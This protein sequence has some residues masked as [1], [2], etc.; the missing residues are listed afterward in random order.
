MSKAMAAILS[1]T[2]LITAA[3]PLT[4]VVALSEEAKDAASVLE[5]APPVPNISKFSTANWDAGWYRMETDLQPGD[6]IYSFD[7]DTTGQEIQT[8]NPENYCLAALPAY[9]CGSDYIV[10]RKTQR[11]DVFFIAE[12]DIVVYAAIDFA[13]GDSFSWESGWT[14]TTDTLTTKDGTTY[15]LYRK[16]YEADTQVVIKKLGNDGDTA[17]NFFL[18]ILPVEGETISKALTHH[19]VLPE[20][21]RNPEHD[22]EKRYQYYTNDVYN[23]S[24]TTG[25][26]DGYSVS[27]AAAGDQVALSEIERESLDQ[28]DLSYNT[29]F[30]SENGKIN[31]SPIDDNLDTYW[32]SN[33]FP[34]SVTVD[35][36][37]VKAVNRLLL[38]LKSNWEDRTQS[39][40]V[41]GSMNGETFTSILPLKEYTFQM[42]QG[43][44][45]EM[46]FSST[47]IRYIQLIITSN[48]GSAGGQIS[49]IEVYGP[50]RSQYQ[51]EAG[52]NLARECPFTVSSDSYKG[53][54]PVDG[55]PTT[56]W[57]SN[58][59]KEGSSESLT[60]DLQRVLTVN[61]VALRL[62]PRWG[63][64][65]QRLELQGSA[66]GT[67]YTT[68]VAASEY[69]FTQWDN[70]VSISFEDTAL[71]YIRLVGT[72]N[73]GDSGI[74]IGELEVFG[75]AQTV[76]YNGNRTLEL[77]KASDGGTPLSLTRTLQTPAAGKVV[78][79]TRIKFDK[80]DAAIQ[81]LT[82]RT[83]EGKDILAICQS[84]AEQVQAITNDGEKDMAVCK[85]NAWHTLKLVLDLDAGTGDIWIDHLRKATG[86]TF[87]TGK[88]ATVS[89]TIPESAAHL[90]IDYL[91]VYD[92]T[93]CYTVEETFDAMETDSCP[94]GWTY[95]NGGSVS[96]AAVPFPEDKS[97]KLSS[98]DAAVEMSRSFSAIRGD[99]TVEVRVKPVSDGWITAPLVTDAAGRT[100]AKVAF[101]HNSIFISNGNN[102]AYLCDQEIPYNYYEADNWFAIKLVMNTDTHRYDAYV[103]GARRYAGASFA[104][105]MEEISQI[106]FIAEPGT[107]LYVNDLKIYD[108]ASLSRGLMPEENVFDVKDYGAI[109]DGIT[110]DTAAIAK[111][112]QAAAGTGGTV[113]LQ[114]GVFYTG[115]VTLES[116][117]T[118]F[119]SPSATLYANSDRHAY[120]K[121]IPSNGYNGNKQLGRGILYFQN[122]KNVR[123]TGGGTIFGNG[124]YAYGENDPSDQR[125]CI[126]YFAQSENVVI[127][128]LNLVQSPFWTLVPYESQQITIRRVNITNHAAPNRDGIDPVNAQNVTIEGC[129]I[130]AGDDAICP[131]S[132]N[133]IPMTDIEVRDCLLQ[134]DCNGIKIGTDTQGP[135]SNLSFEDIHIKKVGLS[136]VTIQSIDGSDIENIRFKR[137]DMNDV[138]NALFVCIGNRY[139]MPIPNPG[140]SK[141]LG[142]IR[143]LRF[144][145][146]RFTNPMDHPYS[147]K[148][149]DNIHEMMLI[150]LNPAYNTIGDGVEHRIKD[151][152]FKNVYLEMPGGATTVPAFT[153]GISNGYPEHDALKTSAGWAYTL[154]WADNVRFVNC[155]S[156]ALKPDV[157][158][159]IAQADTTENEAQRALRLIIDEAEALCG[160]NAYSSAPI[161]LRQSMEEAMANAWSIY[162]NNNATM[163][164]SRQAGTALQA[165]LD[166]LREIV[167]VDKSA[168][169][170]AVYQPVGD[171]EQYTEKS[172][173]VY[174]EMLIVATAVLKD[175]EATQLDVNRALTMLS[176]AIEGLEW[177]DSPAKTLIFS[178]ADGHYTR[179]LYG[180]MFY[181]DWKT[182]DNAPGNMAGT[183]ANGAN[184]NMAL[185]ATVTITSLHEDVN[186]AAAW[187]Q[188]GFRLRSS[189]VDGTEMAAKFYYITPDKVAMDEKG[190]FKVVIPLCDIT[191]EHM[192][193]ED[194]QGLNI[195][196][197]VNAPYRF[198]TTQESPDLTL[199]L[200]D[201]RIAAMEETADP[202]ALN[203]A[204]AQAEQI[205]ETL[206][207][208]ESIENLHDALETA[209][210][211][212]EDKNATQ[213]QINAAA[214]SL[215]EAIALL[216]E[217]EEPKP[218]VIYGDI[219]GDRTIAASDALLA[220]QAATG[221]IVLTDGQKQAADVDGKAG[222]TANDALLI[223]QQSTQK[224]TRFP[225]EN[226][227]F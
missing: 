126:L 95:T 80:A 116:D 199:T 152:L 220:L 157:R 138:D 17:R 211:V 67:D 195:T 96:V 115:Q 38:K 61:R 31:G 119:I 225:V 151:V 109:G 86:L 133:Q 21:E 72:A 69:A 140:Y 164:N 102:W 45:I 92:D 75:P 79:E 186:V 29:F 71:R 87:D 10:T 207:T 53:G 65:V 193:W 201:V 131:K 39:I 129:N 190:S 176:E 74:Q 181:T 215:I 175:V 23:Q 210:T 222:I 55:D 27:G 16:T 183:A 154:R 146:I 50:D 121:V 48:T 177:K 1:S 142:S 153:E 3:A 159:E 130:I 98:S 122:A 185:Q 108:S 58:E 180:T 187:R 88:L 149:G 7:Y 85:S 59:I 76:A 145:D 24:C 144:E 13:Y 44:E 219:N 91:K 182:G 213:A 70:A 81:L 8:E 25:L 9:L 191:P 156:V 124:F 15:A 62:W 63:N 194:V 170:E 43:N 198:P 125:P 6:S 202:A 60:V 184:K 167:P 135:V 227:T 12:R 118:F 37:A 192:N 106:H 173:A 94:P 208:V 155:Q 147:Q 83:V 189:H 205:D 42:D 82:A 54:S 111:A 179:L 110:D 2:I 226:T 93:T 28:G 162:E 137:I 40:E 89:Y 18:M 165:V 34:G 97:L 105:E 204:I 99:V 171:L 51:L 158:Q 134:S 161:S 5:Q 136:G 132:G 123:I 223:L 150:G 200:A 120:K 100:A 214:N 117:M 166:T 197:E 33:G 35:L 143:D 66:D 101:Y 20:G 148:K 139:R 141:K 206:Y 127:E 112:I 114:N 49:E 163:E 160:H 128:D 73:S 41:K 209:K 224:I 196:C 178:K 4:S 107:E 168:L 169:Q 68:L 104:Q 57:R 212:V 36:G 217:K 32:E 26:P 11:R 22:K 64:R 52:V 103:D 30:S 14:K 113:L 46:S 90:Q 77:E 216:V 188:I 47:E 174:Q 221:K 172:V 218:V 19:P 203:A 84:T 78:V 56:Y